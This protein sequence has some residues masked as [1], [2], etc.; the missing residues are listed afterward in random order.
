MT[1]KNLLNK[2]CPI[3]GARPSNLEKGQK[4]SMCYECFKIAELLNN[5]ENKQKK[6]GKPEQGGGF[7]Q[8]SAYFT[9]R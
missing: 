9:N 8:E 4:R 7:I 6:R 1:D 2:P 5:I 3:C